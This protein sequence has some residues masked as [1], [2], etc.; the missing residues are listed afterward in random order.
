MAIIKDPGNS[1]RIVKVKVSLIDLTQPDMADVT[2][3][4]RPM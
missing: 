4:Y 1:V 2:E 3:A